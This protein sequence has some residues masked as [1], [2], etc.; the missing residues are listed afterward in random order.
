MATTTIWD[1]LANQATNGQIDGMFEMFDDRQV[2][3]MT[4]VCTPDGAGSFLSGTGCTAARDRGTGNGF[5]N[6]VY[7]GA[8]GSQS[9]TTTGGTTTGGAGGTTGGTTTGGTGGTTAGGTTTG[10]TGGTTTGGTGGTTTGGGTGTTTGGT[11]SGTNSGPT[12]GNTLNLPTSAPEQTGSACGPCH[13]ECTR[14]M[15]ERDTECANIRQRAA[16]GLQQEGCPSIVTAAPRPMG[17]GGPSTC[18]AAP[19]CAPS[20]PS[21]GCSR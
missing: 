18:Q 1:D 7:T 12:T 2:N 10:G 5:T 11:T 9:G 8:T 14:Q 17:C 20:A 19:S 6:G 3:S 13:D 4:P 15:N 16:W 21:C